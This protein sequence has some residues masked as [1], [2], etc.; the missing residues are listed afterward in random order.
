MNP[1]ELVPAYPLQWPISIP[2]T[3]AGKR[4]NSAFG[5][6][7]WNR[8]IRELRKELQLLGARNVVISTNQPIRKDGEPYAQERRIDDP[9]VAVYC[10]IEGMPVCFPCDRYLSIAENFRAI[11]LHLDSMRGQQ[12][13]GVG[14]A[15]QAFAGY[16]ALPATA[17]EAEPNWWEVLGV[18]A[19]ATIVEIQDAY[20]REAR[21][22]HPDVPG[23]SA[24]AMQRVNTARD[25]AM[26][27]RNA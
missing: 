25:R 20:R 4:R 16:R 22:S 12:R 27:A 24:E 10:L 6:R 19:N 13:W 9:G 17:G 1:Q 3:S 26:E 18:R 23:G 5:Q 7:E 11:T 2:R 15:K 14:T 8:S 21:A